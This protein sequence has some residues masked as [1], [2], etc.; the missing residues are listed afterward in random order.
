MTSDCSLGRMR[1]PIFPSFEKFRDS[2]HE[3]QPAWALVLSQHSLAVWLVCQRLQVE[4]KG[5]N[6]HVERWKVEL[7]SGHC[8][9]LLAATYLPFSQ[10]YKNTM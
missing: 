7:N 10:S 3:A 5:E 6:S 9:K 2:G 1:Y 4:T 8:P